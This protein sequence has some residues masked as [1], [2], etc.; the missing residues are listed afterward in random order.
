MQMVA[1]LKGKRVTMGYSAMR[2]LDPMS[3]AMLAAGGLTEQRHQA[4]AGAERDALGATTSSPAPPTCSCS[5]SARPKVREVD[6]TV[7]GTR[8]L[9]IA[10]RPGMAAAARFRRSAI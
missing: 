10:R 4:G 8:F 2:A 3:R 1:D 7:G 5:R 6:A 9:E